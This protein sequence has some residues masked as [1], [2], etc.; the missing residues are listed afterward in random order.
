MNIK[1]FSKN[2]ESLNQNKGVS[3]SVII[4]T[5]NRHEELK[6]AIAS[7]LRQTVLPQEIIIVDDASSPAVSPVLNCLG[8]P[9]VPIYILRN[10]KSEGPA[11]ARNRGVAAARS[12]WVAFLDDDDEFLPEKIKSLTEFISRDRSGV[13][14]I[15]H[16]ARINMVNEGVTYDTI[17]A[18]LSSDI[19]LYRLLLVSNVIGG[20][21]MVAVK[22][23]ILLSENGFDASLKA[24]EDYELWIRLAERETKVAKL[25][26]I[27]TV[28]HYTTRRASV[29]KSEN[30][31]LSTYRSIENKYR[32]GYS[33]LSAKERK[34][35]ELWKL[36]A[37]IHK[38]VL[39]LDY[40]RTL[41]SAYQ[42]LIFSTFQFRYVAI[43]LAAIFGP[44][45][46]IFIRAKISR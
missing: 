20:T 43:T 27:L 21:P 40:G 1:Q 41:Y 34:M 10:E 5:H 42:A 3:I 17:P 26:E 7:I 35:H 32:S 25:P 46:L 8:L 15:Y 31:S 12:D 24:L 22:R 39:N 44:R 30:A 9:A 2:S 37:M 29:T 23:E 33:Q 18:S 11:G 16:A 38:A 36:D 19:S 28:C 4:A 45:A 6:R 14:L 13:E